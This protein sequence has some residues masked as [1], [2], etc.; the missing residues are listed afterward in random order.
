[1]T[2]LYLTLRITHIIRETEDTNTYLLETISG[3]AID[4]KAGQFL[5]FLITLHGIEFRRSYSLSSAPGID[6][7]PAIT[8]R[9]K[10]NGEISRHI[11]HTWQ[12]GDVV[13]SL[14][15]SGRFTHELQTTPRDIFLLAAGSGIS[16][17]YSLL[18]FI[19]K[20]EPTA[21]V[22]MLYSNTSPQT[23]IFREGLDRLKTQYP[24]TFT[25]IH[26]YSSGDSHEMPVYR[27]LSNIVLEPLINTRLHY[28]RSLAHFYFCGPPDYMRMIQLTLIFMGF[29]ADR[30]HKE[31]FVVNTEAKRAHA[32]IPQ[33]PS[34]KEVVLHYNGQAHTLQVPGNDTLLHAAQ[35]HGLHLPYSCKGGVCGSCTAACTEGKVYMAVNEVLTDAEIKEG[36]ILTCVSYI[37]SDKAVVRW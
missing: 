8:V 21:K 24:R 23:A 18:K 26:F 36:L 12:V 25:L 30:L 17:V 2:D 11:L 35:M 32:A 3:K 19:L 34:P 15:P 1:M 9:R 4:Y 33:D 27:R 37:T 13:T 20:E 14:L 31:N 7:T 6:K 10:Q 5:T 16:P 28:A 22:T 29:N